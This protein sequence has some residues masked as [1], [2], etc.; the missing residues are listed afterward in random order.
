MDTVMLD[1]LENTELIKLP[2]LGTRKFEQHQK[3]FLTTLAITL[4][5]LAGATAWILFQS[6]RTAKQ[7]SAANQSLLQSQRLAKVSAQVLNGTAATFIELAESNDALGKSLNALRDGN[8]AMAVDSVA[9]NLQIDLATVKPLIDRTGKNVK[10]VLEQKAFL[11]ALPSSLRGINR[12]SSELLEVAE[13]ISSLKLQQNSPA[14]EI[15][16]AGELVMLTQRMGKSSGEFL[17]AEGLNT[18]A[19]FILGKDLNAFKE[20][21][22]GLRDGNPELKLRA[23]KDQETIDRIDALLKLYEETRVQAGGILGNLQG[24]VAARDAQNSILTDS[25]PIR[26]QLEALQAKLAQQSDLEPWLV[27]V[28]TLAVLLALAAGTGLIYVQILDGKKRQ[29]QAEVRT[30]A[31][32]TLELEAKRTNDANQ[33]AILRLMN[34]MQNVADGD[35]TQQATVTEDI[36]GAIADSVNYTVEELRNLVGSVQKTS[37]LVASTTTQVASSST[38]LLSAST[39]QLADIQQAGN[40]VREMA[41]RITEASGLADESAAV[42]KQFLAAAN[43]GL[44]AVQ[45]TMGGMNTIRNQI[46]ETAKRMK[47]L[48]ESSQEIGEITDL[49]S[50][51]T[52]QTNVLALNAAIQ[53]ASAGEAGR[54]FTVVAEEVQRLAERSGDA[55]RQISNLVK[56]IQSDTQE[57]VASMEQST[58]GV[59]AGAQLSENAGAALSEIDRISRQLTGLIERISATTA[60]EAKAA[61]IVAATIQSISAVTERTSEGTK[62]NAKMVQELSAMAD[63]LKKSVSRF[64]LA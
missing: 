37:A 11:I 50:D 51:I 30:L 53:A 21:G 42:A 45:S 63:D 47:R 6:D 32:Q 59:V 62:I 60:S 49:I 55:T 48:G 41:G 25:E 10:V 56:A 22:T 58:N 36:T 57:V 19:I 15:S 35:L 14:Q 4:L 18:E 20:L 52:E 26:R 31:A 23:T 46:Q 44:S 16:A 17:T 34:E 1:R 24:M 54:G 61:N 12:R 2:V 3:T 40:S 29:A 64:K 7:L 43:S 8:D 13:S 28:L 9:E 33:A 27:A 38:E 5:V 39:K